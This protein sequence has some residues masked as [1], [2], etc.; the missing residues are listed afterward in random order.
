VQ[1]PDEPVTFALSVVDSIDFAHPV[2]ATA[3]SAA[4]TIAMMVLRRLLT[5]HLR[6]YQ[7]FVGRPFGPPSICL[8]ARRSE[9][10]GGKVL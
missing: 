7:P 8:A 3:V 1:H 9:D 5:I 2:T 6:V 10:A 4:A